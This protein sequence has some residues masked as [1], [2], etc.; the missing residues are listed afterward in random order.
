MVREIGL[1][2]ARQLIDF[3]GGDATQNMTWRMQLEGAVALHNILVREKVAY[4]ADEVGM[5]KTYVALGAVALFRHFNPGWRVLYIAPR[6]NIQQKW[7][8]E[9]LNFTTNNWLVTDNRVKSLQGT[10][11]YGLAMCHSLVDLAREAA[12]N[13]NR[14]FLMRLTSFSFGLSSDSSQWGAKR[15]ALQD[16]VPWS[17]KYPL[18]LRDKER[19]KENYA[20]AVNSILPH[21]DLVV[22]DEGHNLKHGLKSDAARNH[23]LAYVLGRDAE[24]VGGRF[25]NYERRFERVLVLSATPLESDYVEL[26]N[27]L[28]LFGKGA[29]YKVLAD[30]LAEEARKEQTA[31]RFLVRRLTGL[32][33]G[34]ETYTKNMY[35]RE[36]R[37]GGVMQHDERLQVA[38]ERQRL[39][40]ALVQKKV[41]EVLGHERFNNSFQIGMLASFESF[42]E[43]AGVKQAESE[44]VS[45]FDDA[46]QAEAQVEREGIDTLSLNRLAKSYDD[47]FGDSLPHPKMDAIAAS[48]KDRL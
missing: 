43:T 34:G 22:I 4:L 27:Q 15:K 11:A 18:D 29:P 44:T 45:A 26:W 35:R 46:D 40:V 7:R 3:S 33:I 24:Q 16:Y 10:P 28:D 30:R 14:D 5:G 47:R 20:R 19:F 9:L 42:M 38:D 31:S 41:A 6:E 17:D 21:F 1:N 13:P 23:V 25:P 36:W 8:K 37:N 39:I 12:L 2:T 48:L 32:V